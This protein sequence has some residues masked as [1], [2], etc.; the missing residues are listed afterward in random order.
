MFG[1]PRVTVQAH[2]HPF[3]PCSRPRPRAED[4]GMSG[5]EG[6]GVA[7]SIGAVLAMA[8]LAF[9]VVFK[10]APAVKNARKDVGEL[11][12]ELRTLSGVLHSL[13]I[14]AV[15]IESEEEIGQERA[16]KM[17]HVES[18]YHLLSTIRSD[19]EKAEADLNSKNKLKGLQQKLRWPFGE[20]ATKTLLDRI[21][22]HKQTMNLAM[23]A[24]SMSILLRKLSRHDDSS[25]RMADIQSDVRRTLEITRRIDINAKRRQVLGHFMR[26]D[27]QTRLETSVGLRHPFTGLWLTHGD[28]FK[29]WLSTPQS[30]LWLAGIPG[31]GKTVLAGAMIEE[32]LS[33]SNISCAVGYFFCDASKGVAASLNDLLSDLLG[34]LACQ[35][36]QQ[37]DDAFDVLE[38]YFTELNPEPGPRRPATTKRLAAVLFDMIQVFDRVYIVVDGIDEYGDMAGDVIDSLK[39]LWETTTTCSVALL[40]RDE[41][42]IRDMLEDDFEYVKVAARRDD[43][44][45]YVIAQ[46]EEKIRLKKL[47]I[48]GKIPDDV[49]E[50][51]IRTLV[52]GSDG[53]FRWVT[54]QIDYIFGPDCSTNKERLKALKELPPDL[55]ET[56]ERILKRVNKRSSNVQTLVQRTLSLVS[57]TEAPITIPELRQAVSLHPDVGDI[58]N[59]D[60]IV[61]EEAIALRCSS[62]IRKSIDGERFEFAHFTVR[63]FLRDDRLLGT[64]LEQYHI[65]DSKVSKLL[66]STSIQFL[67]RPE[68]SRA[69]IDLDAIIGH[70]ISRHKKNPFY[71]YAARFWTSNRDNSW[72]DDDQVRD[73]VLRLF[74]HPKSANFTNWSIEICRNFL[75]HGRWMARDALNTSNESEIHFLK[76]L[77]TKVTRADFTPLHL[78]AVLAIPWLC[79]LLLE[80]GIGINSNSQVGIPLHCAVVGPLVFFEGDIL[81][82]EETGQMV[83][84]RRFNMTSRHSTLKVLLQAG[85]SHSEVC[86]TGFWAHY[87]L[88]LS[89]RVGTTH[90]DYS[91]FL[92]LLRAG[93]AVD[94]ETYSLAN[95]IFEANEADF[96]DRIDGIAYLEAF[97]TVVRGILEYTTGKIDKGSQLLRA[98]TLAFTFNVR[99]KFDWGMSIK[100]E[101]GSLSETTA[102]R[103]REA[104]F[105]VKFNDVEAVKRLC[106]SSV[107]KDFIN[108]KLESGSSL[109][110]WSVEHRSLEAMQA[111]LDLGADIDSLDDDGWTPAMLCRYNVQTPLLEELLRRGANGDAATNK[112]MTLWHIA[113]YENSRDILRTL[114]RVS[115]NEAMKALARQDS[116]GTT[117]F[118]AGLFK[119]SVDVC[120]L[121]LSHAKEELSCFYFAEGQF[122]YKIATITTK[123]N[124][125]LLAMLDAGI[126]LDPTDGGD[127]PLHYLHTRISSDFVETLKK[128]FPNAGRRDSDGRTPAE[129]LLT[130]L[131]AE[132]ASLEGLVALKTL[133]AEEGDAEDTAKESLQEDQNR[134]VTGKTRQLERQSLWGFLPNIIPSQ[135]KCT[136]DDSYCDTC[137]SH[138]TGVCYF[139]LDEGIMREFEKHEGYSGVIPFLSCVRDNDGDY[140]WGLIPDLTLLAMRIITETKLWVSHKDDKSVTELLKDAITVGHDVLVLF[141]L[142]KEV[143]VNTCVDDVSPLE[144]AS[145]PGSRCGLQTFQAILEN[146]DKA[147]FNNLNQNGDQLGLIHDLG[148]R[149]VK[150]SVRKLESLLQRGGVDVNA[151]TGTGVPAMVWHLRQGSRNTARVLLDN[152]ADPNLQDKN[153]WDSLLMAVKDNDVEFLQAVEERTDLAVNW[154]Q[155]CSFELG[156][157][158]FSDCN[159]IHVAVAFCPDQLDCIEF[160]LL[161]DPPDIFDPAKPDGASSRYIHLA[162]I[163]D[164]EAFVRFLCSQ[165]DPAIIN[166]VLGSERTALDVAVTHNHPRMVKA[167]L[168]LG[169]EQRAD[170]MGI[171]P[172]LMAIGRELLEIKEILES[173][174]QDISFDRQTKEK[175]YVAGMRV[176][177]ERAVETGKI[178][179]CHGLS[180]IGCPLDM[181]LIRCNGCSPFILALREREV[182]IA[183][184]MLDTGA[185]INI[186]EHLCGDCMEYE[187]EP[188]SPVDIAASSPHLVELLPR[189]LTEYLRRGGAPFLEPSTPLHWA[190][191]HGNL[192]GMKAIFT[193]MRENL[194]PYRTSHSVILDSCLT[195]DDVIAKLINMDC[196]DPNLHPGTA[197]H[198]AVDEDEDVALDMLLDQGA[199]PD[200]QNTFGNTPLHAAIIAVHDTRTL[201]NMVSLLLAAGANMEIRNKQWRTALLEAAHQG[202]FA[203]AEMLIEKGAD[204]TVRDER[205]RSIMSLSRGP[206]LFSLLLEKGM[207]LYSADKSGLCP[208]HYALCYP[209]P[210]ALVLNNLDICT[211]PPIPKTTADIGVLLAVYS[212]MR[213]INRWLSHV[214]HAQIV[215]LQPAGCTSPLC[216]AAQHND[217]TAVKAL[218]SVGAEIDFEGS[219]DGTALMAACAM[220]RLEVVKLLVHHGASITTSNETSTRSALTMARSFPKIVRWLLVGKHI[221]RKRIAEFSTTETD[222]VSSWSGVLTVPVQLLADDL[223]EWNN[224][225]WDNRAVWVHSLRRRVAGTV[226][227][228]V[229][230]G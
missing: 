196:R 160:Y 159:A 198:C 49:K 192:E 114:I 195:S 39:D 201:L 6:L 9:K 164:N 209:G 169:A 219:E 94:P 133:L 202:E 74:S 29:T 153:G 80:E 103:I 129:L 102:E 221:E 14:F 116:N 170:S 100:F 37:R 186:L 92:E 10:Y 193:H 45:P 152:G 111:L 73:L 27:P 83:D 178:D 53:M 47:R 52:D 128:S 123:S 19:L 174:H 147:K 126:P 117:P 139:L 215:D 119:G 67:L 36:A 35:L 155:H 220:G 200:A 51:I 2:H 28:E 207:D 132:D 41:P 5:M 55:R 62:L 141:L 3:S 63:E 99:T 149:D 108:M 145:L 182:E 95:A 26:F 189:I 216:L 176:V 57:L 140:N 11:A 91:L 208:I 79:T 76:N 12:N 42:H 172:M 96:A 162:A 64:P 78:A 105:A 82:R 50:S 146:A 180:G 187:A 157:E 97:S 163:S 54:C 75:S 32:A 125:L 21:A 85:A 205:G 23:T 137:I 136:N 197:L 71:P 101:S 31:A 90:S 148:L 175:S 206:R 121:I 69:T 17:Q 188:R 158:L 1:L 225:V 211:I 107:D 58:S 150:D 130:R 65:A 40:S 81:D 154:W 124:A 144:L 16:F 4:F 24:D 72:W 226:Q 184:W 230:M 34:A 112:G 173:F 48:K 43:I 86:A 166:Q 138:V 38:E 131:L 30:K 222:V 89:L 185:D 134:A 228:G 44:E 127:T 87:P 8:D 165:H 218:L 179:I 151:R 171:T 213:L 191:A 210:R 204:A 224:G 203:V 223:S 229:Y 84:L 167:L 214:G 110:H 156:G 13:Q 104:G 142:I 217:L 66:A 135:I 190:A 18:C 61:T 181:P 70:M 161:K 113:A 199:D 33:V 115:G 120:L 25:Q 7:A 183:T 15:V 194:M 68:F 60:E 227:S 143:D 212:N 118:A 168:E 56:Y 93:A 98:S 22:N 77:I 109:L 122:P 106:S 20:A 177:L 59:P 88:C 46:I